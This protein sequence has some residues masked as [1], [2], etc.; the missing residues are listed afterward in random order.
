[1]KNTVESDLKFAKGHEDIYV[2]IIDVIPST[3]RTRLKYSLDWKE[4]EL[5][6]QGFNNHYL[7]I[8]PATSPPRERIQKSLLA[9][10]LQI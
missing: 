1:M 6:E 2:G 8:N 3:R 7:N 5:D 10:G 4:L 9:N